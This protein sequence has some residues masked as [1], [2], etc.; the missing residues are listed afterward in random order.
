MKQINHNICEIYFIFSC[1]FCLLKG[2][3]LLSRIV[4]IYVR[5]SNNMFSH[6]NAL[7]YLCIQ[8]YIHVTYKIRKILGFG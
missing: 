3:F 8:S 7:S 4:L 5:N 1:Y 2:W 6:P